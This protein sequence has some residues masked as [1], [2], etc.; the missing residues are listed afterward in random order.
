MPLVVAVTSAAVAVGTLAP[1]TE[2]TGRFDLRSLV[3]QTVEVRDDLSPLS[4]LPTQLGSERELFEIEL[5]FPAGLGPETLSFVPVAVLDTYDGTLWTTGASF[6]RPGR[7]LAHASRSGEVEVR[8]KVTLLDYESSFL[9]VLHDPVELDG[10]SVGYDPETSTLISGADPSGGLSYRFSSR[11]RDDDAVLDAAADADPAAGRAVERYLLL[12]DRLPDAVT[13]LAAEVE[14]G[15]STP[16]TRL[17]LLRDA[18]AGR[19]TNADARPGHSLVRL[20]RFLGAPG[21]P[22]ATGIGT[23]E[24]AAAVFALVARRLGVPARLVVG[25][26]VEQVAR[27]EPIVVHASDIRV[28]AEALF[29]GVGWVRFDPR[30]ENEVPLPEDEE[31]PIVPDPTD[32]S[33]IEDEPPPTTP[34]VGETAA[35]APPVAVRGDASP[36]WPLTLAG[37]P[38][39]LVLTPPLVKR[40]RRWRRRS[41]PDARRVFGAL[42]EVNDRLRERGHRLTPRDDCQ[43][44]DDRQ[45]HPPG[46]GERCG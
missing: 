39:V 38:V 37:V 2:D 10:T 45:R 9:P 43:R 25:Y 26:H 4:R 8:A 18:L 41:G 36:R 17:D 27:G 13:A 33:N 5:S 15:A 11:V 31:S 46:R 44:C 14:G 1:I 23:S 22:Q 28:Q 40:A 7:E 21:D 19:N 35:P 6:L 16:F 24:Q 42:A 30:P 12:P 20:A 32:P 3:D 34:E 29:A